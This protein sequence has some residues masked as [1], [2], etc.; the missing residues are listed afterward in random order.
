MG[1][2]RFFADA[3]DIIGT[4]NS[5]DSLKNSTVNYIVTHKLKDVGY[6]RMILRG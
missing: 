2:H 1:V 5:K 3:Y 6:T 4:R